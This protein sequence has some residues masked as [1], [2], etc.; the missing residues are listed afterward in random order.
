MPVNTSIS[1]YYDDY[2]EEKGFHRI[3]FRPGVAVQARE[4]TQSQTI[5][6]NQIK[7]VG[8]YLFIDGD[9]VSGAK[10]VV[11]LAAR[12]IRLKELDP[13]GVA[14]NLNN[15][16]D[17]FVTSP[18]SNVIGKVEFVFAKDNPNIGDAPSVVINL[19]R[20]NSENNGEFAEGS[21][22]YFYTN[23]TNALNFSSPNYR[24][25]VEND[26]IKNA[27]ITTSQFSKLVILASPNNNIKIGDA[28]S[29]SRLT[30]RLFVTKLVSTTVVEVNEAVGIDISSELISF[31][32]KGTSP[33]S[34]VT[35]DSSVFYKDGFFVKSVL[36]KIVPDKDTAFPTKM[37]G[38]FSEQ[39]VITSNDDPSLLDPA[40][41]SSNYFAIG[42]D[43]LQID[44][45]LSSL[46][47]LRV[48]ADR[49]A[50]NNALEDNK[51]ESAED[52]IPLIKF[53]KGEIEY[54]KEISVSGELSKSL[55]E[56]TYDESG[57]YVVDQF[58]IIPQETNQENTNL[59]FTVS[60]GKAYVG[61]NQIKTIGPTEITIPK[62][63]STETIESY[64]I[65]TT[66]GN[67]IKITDVDD[68]LIKTNQFEAAD[69]FLEL[70]NVTNPTSNTTQV[71][72]IAYKGMEYEG[73][74]GEEVTYK[75]FYHYYSAR[76][77]VPASWS[78]WS[79]KYG[80]PE[81]EG[82][83]ISEQL[84]ES[85][86][87]LGNFGVA[88]TPYYTLFREP[89]TAGV[90]YWHSQWVAK[91]KD[92]ELIKGDFAVA[93]LD[94]SID[95]ARVVTNAKTF[96]SI[97]NG[98]PFYDGLLNVQQVKSI[99]G[100]SNEYTSHGT[101]A[102]YSAPFFYANISSSGL[103]KKEN[104]IIFDKRPSDSLVFPIN[105]SFVK[106]ITDISTQYNKVF[107]NI[108]FSSGVYTR[109]VSSPENF[110]FGD[111]ILPESTARAN[112]TLLIKT[113]ATAGVSAGIW[114]FEQGTVTISG[115]STILTINL[116]D[117]TF[118]GT[119]DIIIPIETDNLTPRIKTLV[120]NQGNIVNIT[121]ADYPYSLNYADIYNFTGLY[122]LSNVAKYKGEYTTS[123][124]YDY[125][126][127]VIFNGIAFES[128]TYGSN[129][130]LGS[131]NAWTSLV[132]ENLG[133]YILD[134]GQRE[135]YY[136]H[137]W[138]TYRGDSNKIPGNILVTF[139]YFTH[140]G[141]GPC[142][143]DSY[144]ANL[145][146]AL[147][148]YRSVVDSQEYKLRDCMD[149]RPRRIDN[150]LYQ[151]YASS[152]IP[153]SNFNT[154]ATVEYYLGR[155]DRIYITSLLQNYDSPYNRFFVEKGVESTYPVEPEDVSDSTK[156]SIAILDIP[157]YTF[158]AF[159]VKIT[160]DDNKRF[161]M[162]DIGKIEDLVIKL[163][164]AVK[165]HAMEISILKSTVLN[166]NTGEILVKSGILIEDFTNLEKAD[167]IG[168]TFSCVIDENEKECFP[169]INAYNINLNLVPDSDIFVND[170]LITMKYTEEIF[171]SQLEANS[172]I[173]VN[174]GAFNDGIGRA[175]PS[176]KN[177]LVINI[178]L[179]GGALLAASYAFKA[180]SQ[181]LASSTGASGLSSVLGSSP[182]GATAAKIAN[183]A[184]QALA[185]AWNAARNLGKSFIDSIGSI[186]SISKF[187]TEA[188]NGILNVPKVIYQAFEK[189]FTSVLDIFGVNSI[190]ASTTSSSAAAIT[191]GANFAAGTFSATSTLI[192]TGISQ[193]SSVLSNVLNQ[194]ISSTLSGV[195][196]G[197]V[198]MSSGIVSGALTAA[199]AVA[200]TIATSLGYSAIVT[201]SSITIAN[202]VL[203]FA[204]SGFIPGVT[205][206]VAAAAIV[207]VGV[208]VISKV[209]KTIK[210]W[211]CDSRMKENIQFER[212]LTNGLNLYSFEYKK[213]FK[214]IAGKGRY[215]GCL[216]EEVE[217]LYP[218][219]VKLENNGYKSVNYSLIGI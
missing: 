36:Q 55:A 78:A 70:H 77:E 15:F 43:R 101:G 167:I 39:R 116:G 47:L 24:A 97:Q 157:P 146:S 171:A 192:Q 217:K 89:D 168:G 133:Y 141:E 183:F 163:E 11:N 62:N 105:K 139:S 160:Y 34:I 170:D 218:R 159:D 178:L 128:K 150:S 76:N 32:T 66:Y 74:S 137:G 193:I 140:T 182:L 20:Y 176:K 212:R 17:T 59:T 180:A 190:S 40:L 49:D 14:I 29:F 211:F 93:A 122:K 46:D 172:T 135:T 124:T 155:K 3:L 177:S 154:E 5:L 208:K 129:N 19:I 201:S 86:A 57:S 174:P 149:F 68:G 67:Y 162:R 31:R 132:P 52:F 65:N 8:D 195:G 37:I 7:R 169:A 117:A 99:V 18:T 126:D 113:G 92:I 44:L 111:G 115:S 98:S 33:T 61:G 41:G 161:T 51:L 9:K 210:R 35:Q 79:Q 80:I 63:T 96:L 214:D 54:I 185:T 103:D 10:P 143:V 194:S 84:Y 199:A 151:N 130:S 184:E 121:S 120:T 50:N 102:T 138:I 94:D 12:T 202:S 73:Y 156:M 136:D 215:F 95:A 144:P 83:Y 114:K 198:L 188:F 164:K 147:P 119:A 107:E 179:A 200:N 153:V 100:V 58:K 30:K 106:S 26:V 45:S 88:S 203:A 38:Y 112:F 110:P 56:R 1:P 72:I 158:S 189:G 16:K 64:N 219:A 204:Q 108:S 165:V 181:Y 186:D 148:I 123:T 28:L 4:L 42:A 21:E 207:Y 209:W 23:Y 87:F 118:N 82:R 142:T 104:L 2:N 90:A 75:L 22:L 69:G 166:E 91:N 173:N 216:A 6:Q 191:Q 81:N 197:L 27:T 206:V 131:G 134:N 71:G 196:S 127:I 13:S 187:F 125:G 205:V 25:T 175:I 85:N 152:I 53:N 213:E 60:T 109:T 145:Y 48:T